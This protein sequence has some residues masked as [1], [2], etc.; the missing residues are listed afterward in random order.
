M[1]TRRQLQLPWKSKTATKP[2]LLELRSST[3]FILTAVCFASATDYFMYG[4]IVPV[5]PTALENRVGLP[6]SKVQSWISILLAIFS[7]TLLVSSPLFGYFADRIGSRRWPFLFGLAMLGAATALL[8]V[9]THIGLWVV[10]R[11]CQGIAGAIVWV[12]G[13]G[14]VIDTVG[15]EGLGQF[16]GYMSMT[17]NLGMVAGPLLGGVL[18]Q[19]SGYYSVFGLAFG[20][21]GVDIFFRL[22]LIEKKHAIRWQEVAVEVETVEEEQRHLGPPRS[23]LGRVVFL[24]KSYRL[25][26]AL[27]A[28][29]MVAMVWTSFDSV[30]PLFVQETFGWQQTGQGLIFLTLLAPHFFAPLAGAVVDK[31]PRSSRYMTGVSFLI[32]LPAAVLLR[33]VTENS[34]KHKVLLCALLTIIGLCVAVSLPALDLEVFN[35]V[36][37]KEAE[38]PQAFGSDGTMSLAFGLTNMGFASGNLIG[39]FFAGF[40]RQQ[41]GWATMSWAL[42]LV[43]GI[44]GIPVLFF[45]GGSIFSPIEN[46]GTKQGAGT[47]VKN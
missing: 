30:L 41:A 32:F 5:A 34:M 6:H 26:V 22:A 15:K 1:H 25:I 7:A 40:I 17:A 4:L 39:P 27:W 3:W 12:V 42:G 35:A 29:I 23:T 33:F 37:A 8:C 36:G 43:V 24:L 44:S 2:R 21:I 28:N 20:L 31:F 45:M 38:D 11:I 10:G 13:V 18:Y 19:E 14:L 46:A 9:G 16:F 47:D